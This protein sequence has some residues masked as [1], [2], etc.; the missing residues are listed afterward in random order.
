MTYTIN[1]GECTF[2]G[3]CAKEC[4]AECITINKD[5]QIAE[6]APAN[7]IECSHCAMVCPVNAVRA[8]GEKLPEYPENISSAP[9]AEMFEH[10]IKSKRSIRSYKADGIDPED[11]K[12]II[13]AGQ[14]T[15]TASNTQQVKPVVIQGEE[16]KKASAFIAGVF[17]KFVRFGLNPAGMLVLKLFGLSRYAKRDILKGFERRITDTIS[18]NTDIFFFNAPTVVILTYPAKGKRFGRTDSALA[19]QNMMLTAH[20]RGIGSCMI[21]F[22]EAVLMTKKLRRKLGVANDRRI[23]LVFT[24][25]YAKPRYYRYPRRS[26]WK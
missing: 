19:G 25:G 15:A 13:H 16:V 6:I 12:A 7:C 9:S 24:L 11:L 3:L 20:N 10:L 2:C 1:T 22:A 14:T 23:G 8:D 4:P 18:G 21:G 5:G 17:L 26:D